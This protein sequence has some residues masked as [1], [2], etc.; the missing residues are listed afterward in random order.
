MLSE[1]RAS[2][3]N[4]ALSSSRLRKGNEQRQMNCY[5]RTLKIAKLRVA[6]PDIEELSLWPVRHKAVILCSSL[7]AAPGK[8][9]EVDHQDVTSH[10]ATVGSFIGALPRF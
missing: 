4:V 5:D 9:I 7:A 2:A 6:F 8:S 3:P 10:M 1:P